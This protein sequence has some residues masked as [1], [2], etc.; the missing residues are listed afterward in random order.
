MDKNREKAKAQ[1]RGH[2]STL[3]SIKQKLLVNRS[4][5]PDFTL[6]HRYRNVQNLLIAKSAFRTQQCIITENKKIKSLINTSVKKEFA[7]LVF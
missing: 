5:H 6:Y 2:I 4:L 1:T 3:I 7:L